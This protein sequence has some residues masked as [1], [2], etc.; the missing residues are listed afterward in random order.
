MDTVRVASSLAIDG[1]FDVSA[2]VVLAQDTFYGCR[3]EV[4]FAPVLDAMDEALRR[5]LLFSWERG[6]TVFQVQIVCCTQ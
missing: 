6:Q 1:R 2:P 4:V 3:Q 5:T